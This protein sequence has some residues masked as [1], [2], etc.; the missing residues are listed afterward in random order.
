MNLIF[1][2]RRIEVATFV[3]TIYYYQIKSNVI[4]YMIGI[5][6]YIQDNAFFI[7]N[8]VHTIPSHESLYSKS[9]R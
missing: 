6:M 3:L 9:I 2:K 8:K 1:I 5:F 7:L 4:Y